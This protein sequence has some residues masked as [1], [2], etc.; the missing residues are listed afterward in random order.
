MCRDDIPVSF[1][2]LLVHA[3]QTFLTCTGSLTTVGVDSR[4]EIA[5]AL[6]RMVA[7]CKCECFYGK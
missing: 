7:L 1:M 3:E 6:D 5:S 4:L 2:Q